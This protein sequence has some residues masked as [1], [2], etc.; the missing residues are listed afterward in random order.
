MLQQTT[1]SQAISSTPVDITE[2]VEHGESP[3]AIILAIAILIAVLVGSMT[4]LVQVIVVLILKKAT[5]SQ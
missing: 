2:I 1:T 4:K 5:S 3:T